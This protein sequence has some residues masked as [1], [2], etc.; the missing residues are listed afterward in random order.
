MGTA[1]GGVGG[2]GTPG[3]PEQGSDT[4]PPGGLA[5]PFGGQIGGDGGVGGPTPPPIPIFSPQPPTPAPP[6]TPVPPPAPQPP[7]PPPPAPP[8][9]SPPPP[10]PG[11]DIGLTTGTPTPKIV[12]QPTQPSPPTTPAPVTAPVNPYGPLSFEG[13]PPIQPIVTQAPGQPVAKNTDPTKAPP[14]QYTPLGEMPPP[15]SFNPLEPPGTS[16]EP[17]PDNR[18]LEIPP[19]SL[20]IIPPPSGGP[21]EPPIP[22]MPSQPGDFSK[23]CD[24]INVSITS[25][26]LAVSEL[27]VGS[28]STPASLAAIATAIQTLVSDLSLAFQ[29]FERVGF[30]QAPGPTSV[31]TINE[32]IN[33]VTTVLNQTIEKVS[34]VLVA[35][36]TQ[37]IQTYNT[38]ALEVTKVVNILEQMKPAAPLDLNPIIRILEALRE[39]VCKDVPDAIRSLLIGNTGMIARLVQRLID[40]GLIDSDIGQIVLSGSSFGPRVD[41]ALQGTGSLPLGTP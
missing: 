5:L 23:C 38:F 34:T 18:T 4:E 13:G 29:V 27:T 24:E 26:A 2:G 28:S 10:K 8:T 6:P 36:E 33:N 25:I 17:P 31:T 1:S 7:A 19:A 21:S 30:A 35:I 14:I 39:C 20:L 12:A 16:T 9:L 41:G 37:N 3:A 15:T 22:V 32:S 40:R 11:G